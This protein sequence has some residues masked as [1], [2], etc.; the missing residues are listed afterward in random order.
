[1][2]AQ[3][4]I[5]TACVAG[6]AQGS[7]RLGYLL[8]AIVV[9][10]ILR[11]TSV[12]YIAEVTIGRIAAAQTFP[13]CLASCTVVIP[14]RQTNTFIC[15]LKSRSNTSNANAQSSPTTAWKSILDQT[16]PRTSITSKGIIIITLFISNN[17][18]IPTYIHTDCCVNFEPI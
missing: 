3:T 5:I 6:H 7:A 18:P 10:S 9:E 17:Q 12:S 2:A 14:A 4:R 11:D 15:W 1:M 13:I 8:R 16:T